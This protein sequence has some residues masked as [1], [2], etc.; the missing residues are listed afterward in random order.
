MSTSP[1]FNATSALESRLL[2]ASPIL[3]VISP[4]QYLPAI[5]HFVT[6]KIGV[7]KQCTAIESSGHSHK[8]CHGHTL[9]KRIRSGMKHL[10]MNL[11]LGPIRFIAPQN[12]NRVEGLEMNLLVPRQYIWNTEFDRLRAEDRAALGE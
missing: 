2:T 12:A 11:N 10:S 8:L 7:I 5:F 6:G 4:A 9:R 3:T 1:G